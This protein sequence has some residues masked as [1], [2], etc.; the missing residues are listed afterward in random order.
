MIALATLNT[1][2]ERAL[3]VARQPDVAP[4]PATKD[5]PGAPPDPVAACGPST[6][7]GSL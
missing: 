6:P 5:E 3:A 1:T 7:A 4:W 2:L